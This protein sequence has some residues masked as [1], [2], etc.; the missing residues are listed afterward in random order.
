MRLTYPEV[1]EKGRERTDSK[2]G[3]NPGE[4][5]GLFILRFPGT[6]QRLLILVGSAQTYAESGLKGEPWDHVSISTP[7][8]CPFW[9]EM[10]WVKD[11]F[12]A[13]EECVVQFHPPKAN[14]VNNHPFVLHL[15]KPLVGTV[16][17]PPQWCV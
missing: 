3:T 11:L 17:M 16:P 15:W 5:D 6:G 1:V 7:N 4:R 13:D 10:C 12:F 8:R 14:Y 9:D 2:F